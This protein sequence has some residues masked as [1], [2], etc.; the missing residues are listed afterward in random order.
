MHIDD[1]LNGEVFTSSGPWS[2]TPSV[3]SDAFWFLAPQVA[4]FVVLSL[5]VRLGCTIGIAKSVLHP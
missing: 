2:A 3:R 5:L 1:H 4:I